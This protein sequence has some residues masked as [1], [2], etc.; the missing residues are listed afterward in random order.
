MEI[1]GLQIDEERAQQL[2]M[3]ARRPWF[4]EMGIDPDAENDEQ[5]DEAAEGAA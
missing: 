5:A 1:E 3:I 2:I 4:E